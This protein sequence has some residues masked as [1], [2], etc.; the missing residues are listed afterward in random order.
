MGSKERL[1]IPYDRIEDHINCSIC[2]SVMRGAVLTPCGHRYC[3]KCITEWVGRNHSCPCCNSALQESQ[4]YSD[5]QFDSFAETI[6]VERDKA[7]QSYFDQM[8]NKATESSQD[9]NSLSTTSSQFEKILKSHLKST[10]LSHQ[11]YFDKLREDFQRKVHLLDSGIWSDL[12]VGD[13]TESEKDIVKSTLKKNLEESERLA[14]EA[15]DRYLTEHMPA[16]ELLPV[17]VTVYIAGKDLRIPDVVIKPTDNSY[18]AI[19]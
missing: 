3:T 12:S 6:L 15:Y 17:V 16:L 18:Q 13:G 19:G 8:F 7:E 5:V 1:L 11:R 2:L 9:D 4:F 10:L 14:A